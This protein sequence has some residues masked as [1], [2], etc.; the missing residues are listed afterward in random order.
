MS[1]PNAGWKAERLSAAL[2][3][4]MRVLII[5]NSDDDDVD[6]EEECK[7]VITRQRRRESMYP[8]VHGNGIIVPRPC[9]GPVEQ[10]LRLTAP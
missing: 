10:C 1:S 3:P 8:G 6:V 2:R 9:L 4:T 5:V 7:P